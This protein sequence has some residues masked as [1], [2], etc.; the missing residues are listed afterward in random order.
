VTGEFSSWQVVSESGIATDSLA[1]ADFDADG[2]LDIVAGASVL[3]NRFVILERRVPGDV[4]DDGRFNSAD[5]VA[6]FQRGQYEDGMRSNSEFEDGDWNGDRQFNSSDLV[7]AFQSGQYELAAE[8]D[9]DLSTHSEIAGA[10][11][12]GTAIQI[13]PKTK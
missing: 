5:L 6:V 13:F 1:A 11:R 7:L 10:L 2:D 4:N 3:L 9:T 12:R 8:I